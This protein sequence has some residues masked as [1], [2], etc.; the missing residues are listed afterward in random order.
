MQPI[1]LLGILVAAS[2]PQEASHASEA[3]PAA[4][5]GEYRCTHRALDK[6]AMGRLPADRRLRLYSDGTWTETGAHFLRAPTF[7]YQIEPGVLILRER[8]GRNVQETTLWALPGRQDAFAAPAL[9]G[10]VLVCQRLWE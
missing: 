9:P 7:K 5:A 4:V 3:L 1:L 10:G 8:V 2:V 6:L